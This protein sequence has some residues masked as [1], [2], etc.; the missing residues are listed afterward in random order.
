MSQFVIEI[1]HLNIFIKIQNRDLNSVLL[2]KIPDRTRVLLTKIWCLTVLNLGAFELDSCTIFHLVKS[3]IWFGRYSSL[4]FT[5]IKLWLNTEFWLNVS[6]IRI[7]VNL[8][9]YTERIFIFQLFRLRKACYWNQIIRKLTHIFTIW[10][11][12]LFY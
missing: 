1:K 4:F 11:S 8:L 10:I 6:D 7:N 9:E 12:N 2:E 5:Q 3:K